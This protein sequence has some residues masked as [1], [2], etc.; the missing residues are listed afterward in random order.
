MLNGLIK[1]DTGQIE[2]KGRIGAIIALG[3]GF[4]PILSGR[5]NVYIN[6]S[7]LGMSKAE[8]ISKLDEI[9]DFAE[10]SDFI[11]APV[12]SYS[13]GMQVRLGF[14]VA[15]L[16]QP[17][18]LI[19]DEV[20]SVGDAR[21]RAKCNKKMS[22]ICANCATI[23]VSHHQAELGRI[24]Q[25][26]IYLADGRAGPKKEL[27]TVYQE[28]REQEDARGNEANSENLNVKARYMT[29]FAHLTFS[30]LLDVPR[31]VTSTSCVNLSMNLNLESEASIKSAFIN[32]LDQFDDVQATLPLSDL[33]V[34]PSGLVRIK[35]STGPIMLSPGRYY[36]HIYIETIDKG[37]L[38]SDLRAAEMIVDEGP[39]DAYSSHIISA[40]TI[41]VVHLS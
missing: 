22:E 1:P 15:T 25:S 33:K 36:F 18:V 7:V 10:L 17:D 6:S 40:N 24:C 32:V 23:I 20:L 11:D 12:Q 39:F 29:S 21:F 5:E 3:A 2:T 27:K 35:I 38:I 8:V 16:C 34:I 26:G 31:P 19:L 41:D 9:I 30:M 28:Y 13:S 14:A 4:N 37:L